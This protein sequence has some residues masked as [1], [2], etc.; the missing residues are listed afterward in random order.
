M[1]LIS[2]LDVVFLHYSKAFDLTHFAY[3][4]RETEGEYEMDLNWL[5]ISQM[6]MSSSHLQESTSPAGCLIPLV[7]SVGIRENERETSSEGKL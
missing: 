1:L 5:K 3:K 4:N 2:G 7:L 6:G